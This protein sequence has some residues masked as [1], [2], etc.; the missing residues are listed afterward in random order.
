MT[1]RRWIGLV[2]TLV[3]L[4]GGSFWLWRTQVTDTPKYSLKQAA[5]AVEKHDLQ[6]F[7][8]YV[9]L[10]GVAERL[11]DDVVAQ[12]ASGRSSSNTAGE[13]GEALG[14]GLAELMKPRLVDRVVSSVERYVETGELP[15]EEVQRQGIDPEVLK[16]NFGGVEETTIDGSTALVALRFHDMRADTS[17]LVKLRMRHLDGYWQVAEVANIEDLVDEAGGSGSSMSTRERAYDATAKSDL[18]NAMVAM[19]AYYSDHRR[20]PDTLSATDFDPSHGIEVFGVGSRTGY[21]L[22]AMSKQT[23]HVFCVNGFKDA[24]VRRNQSASSLKACVAA[25]AR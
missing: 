23:G 11:V 16:E 25:A 18:R 8:K 5:D 22:G 7:K 9:D 19:E 24:V 6:K 1:A 21:V 14:R 2:V 3:A 13:M 17:A 10:E 15:A 20:Y 12:A 4:A